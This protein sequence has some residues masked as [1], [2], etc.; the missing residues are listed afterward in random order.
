MIKG[1]QVTIDTSLLDL[2]L[3]QSDVHRHAVFG[4]DNASADLIQ[5][6][7]IYAMRRRSLW[8]PEDLSVSGRQAHDKPLLEPGFSPFLVPVAPCFFDI[9]RAGCQNQH[10]L[11]FYHGQL[12]SDADSWPEGKGRPGVGGRME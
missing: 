8:T 12:H 11:E 10:K 1:H 9:E 2:S 4:V 6:T 7:P 5:T 3:S